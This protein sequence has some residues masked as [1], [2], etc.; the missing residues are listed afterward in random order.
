MILVEFLVLTWKNHQWS[1]PKGNKFEYSLKFPI[2]QGFIRKIVFSHWSCRHVTEN[3][4]IS[5][6]TKVFLRKRCLFRNYQNDVIWWLQVTECVVNR[7]NISKDN[8]SMQ[9]MLC[10]ED[11]FSERKYKNISNKVRGSSLSSFNVLPFVK[12][13]N[14]Y[15]RFSEQNQYLVFIGVFFDRLDI[16]SLTLSDNT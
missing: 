6:N 8:K 9:E 3:K 14:G 12:I 1:R 15:S 5:R 10:L 16:L 7:T 11:P 13:L 2:N 4:A